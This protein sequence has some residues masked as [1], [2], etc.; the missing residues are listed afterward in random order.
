MV[1]RFGGAAQASRVQGGGGEALHTGGRP[2]LFVL[3]GHN[4]PTLGPATNTPPVNPT[5]TTFRRFPAECALCGH[6]GYL[7][8]STSKEKCLPENLG[9]LH[10]P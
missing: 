5:V 6:A 4:Q 2:R 1:V 7:S 10:E 8:L 3:K 9:F